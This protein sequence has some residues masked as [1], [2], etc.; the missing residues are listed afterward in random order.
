MPDQIIHVEGLGFIRVKPG[1]SVKDAIA[2]SAQAT[3]SDSPETQQAATGS[4]IVG[5]LKALG[6]AGWGAAKGAGDTAVNL[7]RMVSSVTEPAGNAIADALGLPGHIDSS[8]DFVGAEAAMA[9]SNRPEAIGK[10]LEQIAEFFLPAGK[11]GMFENV[12]G[13]LARRGAT[14]PVRKGMAMKMAPVAD[15]A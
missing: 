11:A 6:D 14:G 7:G 2:A 1:Q 4:K 15:Q 13:S 5:G 12:I 8:Q 3:D 9:P 10:T